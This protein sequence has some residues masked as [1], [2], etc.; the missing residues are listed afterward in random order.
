[1]IPTG[2][3][4]AVLQPGFNR[5]EY[6]HNLLA[7]ARERYG[8]ANVRRALAAPTYLFAKL[9]HGMLP[10]PAPG[11]PPY[12]PPMTLLIRENGQ[13]LA[14]SADGFRPAAPA[15][16]APV[17]AL[18]ADSAFW[19]APEWSDQRCPDAGATMLMLKVPG[20]PEVIRS[21][22]CGNARPTE[23]LVYEALGAAGA[24]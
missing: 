5:A 15:A 1:V 7:T 11:A 8:E 21:G 3:A 20:R 24:L 13:W 19:A 10:P 6:E 17:D 22:N 2:P 16:M 18:L 12:Q 4:P 23:Q 14:A 9:Y